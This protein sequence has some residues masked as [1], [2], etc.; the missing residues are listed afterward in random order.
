MMM[1]FLRLTIS[2]FIGICV[3]LGF[4]QWA[5]FPIVVAASLSGLVFSVVRWPSTDNEDVQAC[6]YA[7]AFVGMC[8]P[9]LALNS[10]DII[11]ISIIGALFFTALKRHF[12]GVGGKLGAIAFIAVIIV[13]FSTGRV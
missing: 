2:F 13:M 12:T 8:S 7:G 4:H 6:G 11:V 3:C 1:Q 10:V 9:S 5:A